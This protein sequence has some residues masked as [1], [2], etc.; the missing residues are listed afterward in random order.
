M[1]G[2]MSRFKILIQHYLR[3]LLRTAVTASSALTRLSDCTPLLHVMYECVS[4]GPIF[5]YQDFVP[6]GSC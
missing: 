4:K 1:L 6:R 2:Y 3:C 5:H